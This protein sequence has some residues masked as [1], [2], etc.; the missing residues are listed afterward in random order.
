MRLASVI[1]SLAA[2]P[3]Q[4]VLKCPLCELGYL[5]FPVPKVG[6]LSARQQDNIFRCP[7]AQ[8]CLKSL[9]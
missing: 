2:V 7:A 3:A 4:K 6:M 5:S 1:H 9:I 8:T